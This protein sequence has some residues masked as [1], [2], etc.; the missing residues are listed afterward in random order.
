VADQFS[1]ANRQTP[2]PS[3]LGHAAKDWSVTAQHEVKTGTHSPASTRI[4]VFECGK[5]WL[6]HCEAEGPEV[7]TIRQRKQHLNLHISPVLGRRKLSAL[8][9]PSIYEFDAGLRKA[10][11][12]LAMRRKILTSLKTMVTFAQSRGLVAQNVA[13]SVKIK[14]DRRAGKDRYVMVSTSLPAPNS[15]P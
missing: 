13:R 15:A 9:A 5:L 1:F 8:T 10:G 3:A 6:D 14:S 12:S 2:A 4:T 7:S 11:T